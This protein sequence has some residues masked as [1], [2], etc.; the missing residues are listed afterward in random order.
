[1]WLISTINW[2]GN[3]SLDLFRVVKGVTANAIALIRQPFTKRS[4]V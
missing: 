4:Q 1:M 2:L 3:Y